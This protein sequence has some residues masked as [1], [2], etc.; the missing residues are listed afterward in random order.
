M[1]TLKKLQLH[2]DDS[3]Y[4]S[5]TPIIFRYFELIIFKSWWVI[6]LILFCGIFFENS[7][8]KINFIYEKLDLRARELALEKKRLVD[9]QEDL[10][11]QVNSQS[12]PSWIELTLIKELGL[13]PEGQTKVFFKDQ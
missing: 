13:V 1:T 12:D 3:E 7:T 5:L 11:L 9:L 2:L 6:A 10:K 4:V 8:K